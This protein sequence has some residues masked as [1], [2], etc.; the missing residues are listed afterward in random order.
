LLNRNLEHEGNV[1]IALDGF[2]SH[3]VE[4]ATTLHHSDL[5]AVNTKGSPQTVRPAP[6]TT[7]SITDRVRINLPAASWNVIRLSV[8]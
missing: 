6:L 4:R 7:V 2:S 1:E 8:A 5:E 3:A